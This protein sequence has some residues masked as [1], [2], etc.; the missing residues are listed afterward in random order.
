VGFAGAPVAD[1]WRGDRVA[2]LERRFAGP[3]ATT[4]ETRGSAGQTRPRAGGTAAGSGRAT[5]TGVFG[6]GEI[7]RQRARS[8][9]QTSLLHGT[10]C[11]YGGGL[12]GHCRGSDRAG[13]RAEKDLTSDFAEPRAAAIRHPH[14]R[15]P[16]PAADGSV[17]HLFC[18]WLHG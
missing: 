4:A 7:L 8:D 15:R 9:R 3:R 18:Q 5:A 12:A 6:V 2:H 10:G 13:W 16:G 14:Y 17:L 1:H 11:P